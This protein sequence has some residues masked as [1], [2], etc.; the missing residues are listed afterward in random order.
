[1]QVDMIVGGKRVVRKRKLPEHEDVT[2]STLFTAEV[3]L[4]LENS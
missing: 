4:L 1:M 3:I 2:V